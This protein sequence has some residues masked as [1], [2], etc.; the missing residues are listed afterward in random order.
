M[1]FKRAKLSEEAVKEVHPSR[2]ND[3]VLMFFENI[4]AMVRRKL[5]D[6]NLV[7][8]AFSVDINHYWFYFK[9]HV[10]NSREQFKDDSLYAEM[11]WLDSKMTARAKTLGVYT[12]ITKEQNKRFF[13]LEEKRGKTIR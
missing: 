7:Y 6:R 9:P 1:Q 8:N 5:V 3:S 4:G 11:E 13:E 12:D 10:I 2:L